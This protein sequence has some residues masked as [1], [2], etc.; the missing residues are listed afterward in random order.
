MGG[1]EMPA[2]GP[3]NWAVTSSLGVWAAQRNTA[4]TQSI[5]ENS[6]VDTRPSLLDVDTARTRAGTSL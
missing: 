2:D 4:P 3:R 1:G 5:Q 6:P